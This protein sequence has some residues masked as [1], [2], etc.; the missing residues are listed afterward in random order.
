MHPRVSPKRGHPTTVFRIGF[1]APAAAGRS[2]VFER[3]YS[4]QLDVTGNGCK[5]AAVQTVPE[6]KA[7]E[8]VRLAFRPGK[9]WCR[10]KGRGTIYMSEGPICDPGTDPCPASPSSTRVI[11][12]FGF[13]VR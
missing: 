13:R 2:G 9:G 4:V 11:A 10:G 3:D 5:Q 7:G 8:R 12:R 6:A 1:T